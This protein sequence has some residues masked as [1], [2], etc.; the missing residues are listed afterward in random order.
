MEKKQIKKLSLRK[1]VVSTLTKEEQG[2]VHG[3]G[4]TS[5]N[6]GKTTCSNGGPCCTNTEPGGGQGCELPSIGKSCLKTNCGG[7]TLPW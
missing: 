7:N 4:T 1:E 2:A 5:F 3:A 6:A